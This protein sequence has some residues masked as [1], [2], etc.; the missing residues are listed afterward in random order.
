MKQFKLILMS[1]ALAAIIAACGKSDDDITPDPKPEIPANPATPTYMNAVL[2]TDKAAYLPGSTVNF[3]IDNSGL[4]ASAKVR[5]KYLGEVIDEA[6][7]SGSSWTWQAPDTDFRGYAVEVYGGSGDSETIY[8]TVGVDVSSD[9]TKF[10]RYGFLSKF[11]QL[12][13]AEMSEVIDNLNKYHINGLQFYDWMNKHHMPLPVVGGSPASS[14]KD[15]INRDIYFNTVEKYIEKAHGRNMKAMFYNLVYGAWDNAEADG[16]QKEWYVFTDNGHT[17][18]DFHPLSSPFLSNIYLLDPS[19]IGWQ[20]FLASENQNVYQFLDFDGF[21][22]DQLGD[23]GIRYKYD[24]SVL[25]LSQT[26]KPFIEAMKTDKP[27]KD[28]AMNAVNQYGQQGI[29]QSS[30]DFLYTEVWSPNDTYN[31]L[32]YIIQQN[33]TYSN[34]SKN[35]VLAAYMNYDLANNQGYFNTPAVLMTDAVIFAFGGAHLELGEH[36]L[37]KEYFPNGNLQMKSDLKAALPDYYDFLV[38]YQNLLRD[39]GNFNIASVSSTDGKIQIA[40]WPASQ[41]AVA[42][43]CKKVGTSQVIHLINFTDSKSQQWRDNS[44]IQTIPALIKDAALSVTSTQPVTKVWVASPD[45]IGGASRSLEFS[46]SG[47]QVVFTLPELKYWTMVVL[48]YE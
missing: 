48:E 6:A 46:Q 7:V 37:G 32:S 2:Q 19:N 13:D 20:Q 9:W 1:I 36:M 21:H 31:D 41:G 27:S 38:A 22:M 10:P 34:N 28:I 24:G 44:G 17:N 8:A 30:A 12:T 16:V 35:S 26:Y 45:I 18:R 15:I 42:T 25:N 5:Y 4:P 11:P 23:R 40:N 43:V 3:T 29:A 14:W 39:G 33:N 47:N